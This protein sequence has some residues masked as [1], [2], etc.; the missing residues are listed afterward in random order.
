GSFVAPPIQ[1]ELIELF[2]NREVFMRAGARAMPMPPNGRIVFPRHT[3]PSSAYFIGENTSITTSEQTSGDLTLQ[4]KKLAARVT[5]PN[6]LFRFSSVSME[7][8][9]RDDIA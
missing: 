5:V 4:A 7:M 3:G 2:R 9:L 6:E 8:F 1:G